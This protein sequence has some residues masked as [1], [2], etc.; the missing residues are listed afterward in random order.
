M[1]RNII[2]IDLDTFFVSVERLLN[3]KLNGLPVIIGSLSDRGVVAGCSYETRLFGVHSGMPMK[4]AKSLCS[5][6]VFIRGDMDSYS[7]YSRLVTDIVAESAPLYEKASIDEHYIDMTG[8][9]RFY[10]TRKW[11]HELRTKIIRESG[12]PISLGLSVNKVVSKIATGEAKP[13]GERIVEL[14]Q[15]H[16]FLDP[17]SIS[18]IPMLGKET[19]RKLM[20]MGV[21]DIRTLR[22]M[23][24]EMLGF[25]FGQNGDLLWKRA[26]GI[27]HTPVTQY[28]EAK[29][30]S[31]ETTF[32]TDTTDV[33]ML[34]AVLISMTEKIAFQMRKKQ[35]LTGVVTV[36]IRYSDF[37]THTMQKRISYTSFDHI[38]IKTSLDLFQRIYSRRVLVR[39]IGVKFSELISG[40]QQL[41][42]FED[43]DEM[44]NLY[45]A[46]DRIRIRFGAK[47]VRRAING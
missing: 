42:M 11:A 23:P 31:T 13:N 2:H 27:D 39:L 47:A 29:S 1:D 3:S 37:D 41:N 5:D 17:L 22:L 46:M 26:N 38:L 40:V 30:I 19:A 45:Q 35:K 9:D 24:Q 14:P 28:S 43:S 36:K 4:M 20:R 21:F 15:I 18:K 7:K 34:R 33:E 32:E 12:L 8:M 44:V 25:V 10:N 16:D 6:A